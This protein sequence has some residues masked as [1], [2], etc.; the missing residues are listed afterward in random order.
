MTII[1]AQPLK[2]YGIFGPAS[3]SNSEI[4]V[5]DGTTGKIIKAGSGVFNPAAGR[6][7]LS[8][9]R[10]QDNTGLGLHNTSGN[11]IFVDDTGK[12]GVGTANPVSK[13]QVSG[14]TEDDVITADI[15][16]DINPVI[17][18]SAPGLTLLDEAG[19]IDAGLHYYVVTYFTGLGETGVSAY[20]SISTDATHGKVKVT[21]PISSDYRVTG[22]KIYRAKA[23]DYYYYLYF[24][25]SIPDNATIEYID[26]IADAGLGVTNA[27]FGENTTA[28]YL[29]INGSG[30]WL[31]GKG[32]ESNTIF[33]VDAGATIFAGSAQTGANVLVGSQAGQ[34]I[35]T[36]SKN[37]AFGYMALKYLTTGD[38]N[39]AIGWGAL[40]H[41]TSGDNNVAI[42]HDAGIYNKTGSYNILIG[43]YAGFGVS[44]NSYSYNI[45]VGNKAGY[46]NTIGNY[47][48]CLGN[49][50]GYCNTTGENNTFVGSSAGYNASQKVDAENSIALGYGTY[51]TKDNQVVIGNGS[52]IET[53]LKGNIGIGITSPTATLHIKAGTASLAP[54]KFT[55]GVNLTTPEPGAV[56]FDGTTLY[57]TQSDGTRKTIAFV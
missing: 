1:Q 5:F 9:I 38:S 19:N 50:A 30:V 27:Y 22:R 6:L 36:G 48:T 35:T 45:F 3:A 39:Q 32:A 13:L 31:A 24:V 26:N 2:T 7:D 55:A 33:G 25:A 21:L 12:V 46:K 17:K 28:K 10:A 57:L 47:N 51:T 56:E 20:S 44:N 14:T 49:Y 23:G 18:P 8:E 54:L 41:L 42:G 43:Y 4:P 37:N 40:Y 52:V 34:R 15:G 11:G 16:L 53:L 29:T